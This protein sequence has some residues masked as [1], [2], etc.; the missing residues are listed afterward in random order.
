[1]KATPTLLETVLRRRRALVLGV[2]GEGDLIQALPIA[3]FLRLAGVE[4]VFGGTAFGWWGLEGGASSREPGP[5]IYDVAGLQPAQ[6]LA[7]HV[8]R[9]A[10]ASRYLRHRPAEAILA[11]F[12]GASPLVCGLTGGVNGLRDSLATAISELRID[13]VVAVDLGGEVAHDGAVLA[14]AHTSMRELAVVAALSELETPVIYAFGGY[15]AADDR[16]RDERASRLLRATGCLGAIEP[17]QS[18]MKEM[19]EACALMSASVPSGA[20]RVPASAT[21]G[22][23]GRLNPLAATVLLFG[24]LAM[25]DEAGAARLKATKSL[26]AIER[27]DRAGRGPSRQTHWRPVARF[28]GDGDQRRM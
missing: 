22:G 16:T 26:Q 20:S 14:K 6:A 1:M 28:G 5:P 27:L 8:V 11:E 7:R 3:H 13:L 21:W 4:V 15:G 19:L 9:V 17:S 10:S 23:A 18:E 25:I 24:P 2:S 12:L